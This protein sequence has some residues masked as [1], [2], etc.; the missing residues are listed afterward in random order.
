MISNKWKI[1]TLVCCLLIF[2]ACARQIKLAESPPDLWS[3]NRGPTG[4]G[5]FKSLI[6]SDINGD[7]LP[8]LA[9]GGYNPGNIKVWQNAGDGKFKDAQDFFPDMGEVRALA[10]ADL[11]KDGKTDLVSSVWNVQPGIYIWYQRDGGK[12]ERFAV[13]HTGK[14]EDICIDDV[15]SDGYPDIIAANAASENS[16]GIQIWLGSKE[17]TWN[18][19]QGPTKIGIFRK[20]LT[21][22]LNRDGKK[23]IL[24]SGWGQTGGIRLWTGNGLGGWSA[25][26]PIVENGYYRGLAVADF[27]GDNLLDVIA[28]AF[29]KGIEVWWGNP[30]GKWEKHSKVVEEGSFWS[31]EVCDLNRDQY[32]DIVASSFSNQGMTVFLPGKEEW[33]KDTSLSEQGSYYDIT[34]TDFNRDGVADIAAASYGEGIKVWVHGSGRFGYEI[35]TEQAE[36]LKLETENL[37]AKPDSAALDD[38]QLKQV[39]ENKVFKNMEGVSEYLIGPKDILEVTIW[40]GSTFTKTEAEVDVQGIISIP[41]LDVKVGGVTCK[42]AADIAV[43]KLSTIIKNP[44]A[45]VRVKEC[46]SKQ[47]TL[48]GAIRSL[49]RQPTGPGIYKLCGKTSLMQMISSAGGYTEKADLQH[50]R[51]NHTEG[52]TVYADMFKVISQGNIQEDIVLDNGDLILIPEREETQVEES[53]VYIFGEVEKPGMYNIKDQMNVLQLIGLAGG[54]T[55]SAVL[56][57]THIIRGDLTRPRIIALN[58][59]NLLGK[60][61]LSENPALEPNDI[62]FIPRSS[63]TNV[64]SY[65]AKLIPMLQ[66]FLYPGLYRDYYTTGG[67]L[68]LH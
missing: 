62:V 40:E 26:A 53:K 67:G 3:A 28:S 66:F 27:N 56:E 60:G 34:C 4:S 17:N 31:L 7:G 20:V 35:K 57:S 54:Y 49:S 16:G 30:D 48:L 15:N 24:A 6:A 38:E 19:E 21:A 45:N 2:S 22:D 47:V 29:Q 61:D 59:E 51:I 42:E 44:R 5:F 58:L 32:D 36:K 18:Q 46:N 63:L 13:T 65:F 41:Y 39:S 8:D 43:T 37:S 10:A 50:I 55:S 9:G 11:D 33:L 25:A 68:R 1:L 23:D 12:W 64:N 52:Q 14:Y